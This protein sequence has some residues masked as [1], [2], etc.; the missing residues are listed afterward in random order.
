[1]ASWRTSVLVAASIAGMALGIRLRYIGAL[2]KEHVSKELAKSTGLSSANEIGVHLMSI[3]SA[4]EKP[5]SRWTSHFHWI[6]INGKVL[7]ACSDDVA[8]ILFIFL[9]GIIVCVMICSIG[10]CI[11]MAKGTLNLNPTFSWRIC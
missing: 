10:F 11:G 1:M 5:C 3:S 7:I 8:A 2:D 6:S 9:V 4:D